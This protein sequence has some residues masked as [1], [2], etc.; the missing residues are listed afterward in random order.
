MI[1]CKVIN[2]LASSTNSEPIDAKG[3]GLFIKGV[4]TAKNC[5]FANNTVQSAAG[6]AYGG[7]LYVKKTS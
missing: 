3:G 2:N 6:V 4:L 5:L 1:N 7:G